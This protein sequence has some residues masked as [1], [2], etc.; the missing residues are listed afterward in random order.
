[1]CTTALRTSQ[2][3]DLPHPATRVHRPRTCTHDAKH[4]ECARKKKRAREGVLI[5]ACEG[6]IMF[7]LGSFG[8]KPKDTKRHW[9]AHNSQIITSR[10]A[11]HREYGVQVRNNLRARRAGFARCREQAIHY[12]RR[13]HLLDRD[14]Y[15][16]SEQRPVQAR[17]ER[18]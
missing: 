15:G 17:V 10:R 1:M 8:D 7:A 6:F 13:R 3:S 12:R 5:S 14:F 2:R 16:P 9:L 18:A 11:K 4:G